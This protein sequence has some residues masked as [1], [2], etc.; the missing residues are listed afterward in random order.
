LATTLFRGRFA[1]SPT[2]PLHL[3]NARTALVSWLAAR[4]R[5]GAYAMRVEDLDGPRVRPGL[6]ARI[7]DELRWLGLD[8]DEG[9]DT[10]GPSAPYR[11][12]E[13]MPV[14]A[15]AIGRL[16]EAD[17]AYPCFC[18]RAEIAA[19]SQAPHGPSD[20]G[21]RYPGTCAHL[22]AQEAALRGS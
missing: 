22:S 1:P 9:P 16:R 7:L 12:S 13:R 6:E 18:S 10:G 11:Q 14:Y 4:A 17:L 20:E 5:G 8:W 3:G 15:A 2:G 19:A 21:P